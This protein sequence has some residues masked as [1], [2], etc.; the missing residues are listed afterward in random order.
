MNSKISN[1][2]YIDTSK[3]SLYWTD[4]GIR[5]NIDDFSSGNVVI[6]TLNVSGIAPYR[7]AHY[8]LGKCIEELG[9]SATIINKP[10]KDHPEPLEGEVADIIIS[11]VDLLYVHYRDK[12]PELTSNELK[13]LVIQKFNSVYFEKIKKWKNNIKKV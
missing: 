6:D 2:T 8:V 9:E 1:S 3:T 12:H 11:S 4:K 13:M 5:I 7:T 10:E